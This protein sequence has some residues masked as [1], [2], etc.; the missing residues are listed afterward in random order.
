MSKYNAIGIQ[1]CGQGGCGGAGMQV[2]ADNVL[3]LNN[4]EYAAC[5][6]GL[7]VN[8]A[9]E[10]GEDIAI[11]PANPPS[12]VSTNL[13]LIPCGIDFENLD[14]GIDLLRQSICA[15]SSNPLGRSARS[16]S[17]A[18]SRAISVIRSSVTR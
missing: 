18:G 4:L 11:G 2:N 10:N 15:T 5:P 3:E 13:T 1:A 8:F 16:Q 7:L 17:T 14:P 12:V 6:G 9:A